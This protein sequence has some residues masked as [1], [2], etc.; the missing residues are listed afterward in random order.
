MKQHEFLFKG[1]SILLMAVGLGSCYTEINE[2]P[3]QEIIPISIKAQINEFDPPLTRVSNNLF[4]LDD[5]IG[6]FLIDGNEKI[7]L[8]NILFKY[9]KGNVFKSKEDVYYPSD[10]TESTAYAYYPYNEKYQTNKLEIGFSINKNQTSSKSIDESDFLVAIAE[11]VRSSKKALELKFDHGLAKVRLS[12]KISNDYDINDLIKINPKLS[13]INFPT[14]AYYNITENLITGLTN[15][16]NIVPLTKWSIN[17]DKLIGCEAI[18]IPSSNYENQKIQIEAEGVVY[19][20]DLPTSLNL[21]SNTVNEVVL[22]F[23][24]SKGIEI[25]QVISDIGDWDEGIQLEVVP[26]PLDDAISIKSL[27]FT[28]SN[29]LNL[30]N[31]DGIIRAKITQ[32]LLK[33]TIL[34]LEN[35]AIIIY[36]YNNQNVNYTNGIILDIEIEDDRKD[37]YIL[38]NI[39][40]NSNN[41]KIT[42]SKSPS[43]RYIFVDQNGDIKFEEPEKSEIITIK[44]EYIIDKR[45][46]ELIEYPVVKLANTIWMRRNLNT[47]YFNNGENL[48]FGYNKEVITPGYSIFEFSPTEKLYNQASILSENKLCPEGWSLPTGQTYLKM[49]EYVNYKPYLICDKKYSDNPKAN[50]ANL[51]CEITGAYGK[52]GYSTET[53]AYWAYDGDLYY[54]TCRVKGL[55]AP[56]KIDLVKQDHKK[57]CSVRCVIQ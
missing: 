43:P 39:S 29:I 44:E 45:N 11:E 37:Q 26:H 30:I 7:H 20:C 48:A 33:D 53:L 2:E 55:F 3:N 12:L 14:Q 57:S 16:N 21:K 8:E 18:I 56:Y 1:L 52:N 10:K 34:D 19:E 50:L 51:Y 32:E 47:K 25:N 49:L 36:P 22:L 13:L 35:S 28:K 31:S 24:P 17:K 6:F 41:F 38:S 5:E 42:P 27:D 9:S 54:C 23:T 46:D 4:E 15:N 40:W